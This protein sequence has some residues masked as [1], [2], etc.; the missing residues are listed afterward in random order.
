MLDLIENK[1]HITITIEGLKKLVN[2]KAS[3]PIG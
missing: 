2:I 1:S 3:F